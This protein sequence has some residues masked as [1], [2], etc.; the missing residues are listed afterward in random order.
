MK[1]LK[2]II[3]IAIISITVVSFAACDNK[4]NNTSSKTQ[5]SATEEKDIINKADTFI[6]LLKEQN[7][8]EMYKLV[9]DTFKSKIDFEKFKETN[10]SLD[11]LGA[12]KSIE[13]SKVE[14]IKDDYAVE[15]KTTFETAGVMTLRIA[16][17]PEG[18]VMGYFLQPYKEVKKEVA[19]DKYKSEEVTIGSDPWKLP[20]TLLM[21]NDSKGKLKV[22]VLVHGTGA[23]N[24]DE[25]IMGNAPFR[26]IARGLAERGIAVLKYDKRNFVYGPENEGWKG[27][28]TPE[29]LTVDDAI[30]AVNYLKSRD[31]IDPNGIFVLGHSIGGYY[32]PK[33]YERESDL[34]GYIS[35]AGTIKDTFEDLVMYQGD[36]LTK[37]DGKIDD[38]DK[39]ILDQFETDYANI[40]ELKSGKE[41]TAETMFG[42]PHEYWLSLKEYNP[43]KIMQTIDKPMLIVQGS[44]D[45][46]VPALYYEYYK[47]E[48]SDKKNFEFKLYDGL[49]HLFMEGEPT[50]EAYSTK[51]H[52]DE[53]VI[54]DIAEWIKAK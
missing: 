17:T 35:L 6:N 22:V 37:L 19:S 43:V 52:V 25:D 13:V 12:I 27:N 23:N 7:N 11:S 34:A 51:G 16:L 53:K 49:T 33:I 39:K 47:S 3:A 48:L 32:M 1:R 40:K 24:R 29:T 28:T 8:E 44:N 31:E 15:Y 26:D 21:P 54:E 46:Q 10:A 20:G 5:I 42:Y 2:K 45:Y 38:E 30:E 14:K 9:D 18:K 50:P 41:V 36:Y 4:N